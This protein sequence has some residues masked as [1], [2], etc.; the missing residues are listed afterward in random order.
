MDDIVG[1]HNVICPLAHFA[2]S[3]AQYNA[4]RANMGGA[5]SG[6]VNSG[7]NSQGEVCVWVYICSSGWNMQMGRPVYNWLSKNTKEALNE[8]CSRQ[9][10]L[11][12][13][14]TPNT[15]YVPCPHEVL[16]LTFKPSG[17]WQNQSVYTAN[18]QRLAWSHMKVSQI[19]PVVQIM[20]RSSDSG[21][22]GQW[23]FNET[24]SLKPSKNCKE[25]SQR[26]NFYT[27]S[28]CMWWNF[29]SVQPFVNNKVHLYILHNEQNS[30]AKSPSVTVNF[31][32]HKTLVT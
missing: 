10:H 18:L 1:D 19:L 20:H 2:R 21:F 14:W 27:T 17:K 32:I 12:S 23:T 26:W 28:T 4:L 3:Y 6:V 22:I 7:G 8:A 31:T 16:L 24:W 25:S 30:Q 11:C 5:G 29:A 15:F 13:I 9:I